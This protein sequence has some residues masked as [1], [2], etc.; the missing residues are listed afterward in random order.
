MK[1]I[2]YIR[3]SFIIFFS[4]FP[5]LIP[6]ASLDKEQA[7]AKQVVTG[8]LKISQIKSTIAFYTDLINDLTKQS[9]N[10]VQVQARIDQI[11]QSI[12]KI[13]DQFNI[14]S[15]EQQ[16]AQL[17]DQMDSD[18]ANIYAKAY[19]DSE[20]TNLYSKIFKAIIKIFS[21]EAI[22]N[23]TSSIQ[24]AQQELAQ[25][26]TQQINQIRAIGLKI[27]ALTVDAQ[28]QIDPILGQMYQL[29]MQLITLKAPKEVTEKLFPLEA[30]LIRLEN[31]IL[32]KIANLPSESRKQIRNYKT[33]IKQLQLMI[34]LIRNPRKIL[35]ITSDD[36]FL[37][38][39]APIKTPL[40]DNLLTFG[41]G[42]YVIYSLETRIDGY[43]ESI[44]TII[45]SV[46]GMQSLQD[47]V[48]GLKQQISAIKDQFKITPVEDQITQLTSQI[49]QIG[50]Q[51]YTNAVNPANQANYYASVNDI[52]YKQIY[53]D[54]IIQDKINA[55]QDLQRRIADSIRDQVIQ[56]QQD[57]ARIDSATVMQEQKLVQQAG[58]QLL[59][60]QAQIIAAQQSKEF[61]DKMDPLTAEKTKLENSINDAISK[62][63]AETSSKIRKYQEEIKRNKLMLEF[64][65]HPRKAAT[66][67]ED[68]IA[69]FEQTTDEE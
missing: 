46:F 51:I 19:S 66:A 10:I 41:P 37:I 32:D 28:R 58:L 20:Q 24:R 65:R 36:I 56:I 17:T 7:L 30:Q 14:S 25:R 29:Q 69:L 62:L 9:S 13:K 5:H 57:G 35:R 64:I 31:S 1:K 12:K 68:E 22:K 8:K 43:N 47:Q 44:N 60:L 67:T 49:D 4:F 6:Q 38:D 23:Y 42:G 34:S 39:Q 52:I 54:D 21:N 26:V 48:S 16:I 15:L 50:A 45:N 40:N 11:D 59:P 55:I 61:T 63:P 18:A 53:A 3:I 2:T 27:D 33:A